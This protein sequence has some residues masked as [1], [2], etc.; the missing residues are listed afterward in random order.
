MPGSTWRRPGDD[1]EPV[2]PPDAAHEP[3]AELP[4]LTDEVVDE[5][6]L[7]IERIEG[8][9]SATRLSSASGGSPADAQ[10]DP[11]LIPDH[12]S[13]SRLDWSRYVRVSP[14]L[15]S[16]ML[17]VAIVLVIVAFGLGIMQSTGAVQLVCALCLFFGGSIFLGV[18]CNLR[19][20]ADN[21]I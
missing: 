15:S 8:L 13:F 5:R 17:L 2:E 20:G 1:S 4:I 19:H 9:D 6:L 21:G 16:A 18:L 3:T 14:R 7:E 12:N 11:L 10:S